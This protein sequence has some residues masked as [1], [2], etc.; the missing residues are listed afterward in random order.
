MLRAVVAG[1]GLIMCAI[2]CCQVSG[3]ALTRSLRPLVK[4]TL[5]VMREDPNYIVITNLF[6]RLG[7]TRRTMIASA[8]VSAR[9][10]NLNLHDAVA[11]KLCMDNMSNVTM[12]DLSHNR[13]ALHT[14]RTLN[15][16]ATLP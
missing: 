3:M 14:T 8:A 15:A 2:R 10:A 12:L 11:L 1:E 5:D 7:T 6:Q 4:E 16:T 13:C 9:A